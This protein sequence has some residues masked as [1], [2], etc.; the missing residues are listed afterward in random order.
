M[1]VPSLITT[2]FSLLAGL[3]SGED[4]F[5]KVLGTYA[6]VSIDAASG[7]GGA[8]IYLHNTLTLSRTLCQKKWFRL[9]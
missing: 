9:L 6:V 3:L 7:G 8:V 4:N 2:G 1:D 5:G